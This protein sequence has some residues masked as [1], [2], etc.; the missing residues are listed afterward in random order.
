MVVS[1][2][3]S[4]QEIVEVTPEVIVDRFVKLNRVLVEPDDAHL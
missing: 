1:G 3:P 2:L 4:P